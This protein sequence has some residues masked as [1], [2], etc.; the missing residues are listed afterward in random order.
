MS[1]LSLLLPSQGNCEYVA[2]NPSAWGDLS[3]TAVKIYMIRRCGDGR[4]AYYSRRPKHIGNLN[5]GTSIT[6][7]QR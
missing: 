4:L 2:Y 3:A 1:L 7:R 6:P 5:I